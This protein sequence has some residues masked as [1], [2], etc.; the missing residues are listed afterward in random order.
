MRNLLRFAPLMLAIWSYSTPAHADT[1]YLQVTS[2][3]FNPEL[4]PVVGPGNIPCAEYTA[5]DINNDWNNDIVAGCD[6]DQVVVNWRGT[7]T[8][9][10]MTMLVVQHISNKNMVV[11]FLCIRLKGA[12]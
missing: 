4:G 6:Y 9:P 8:V 11:K 7:L 12:L 5:D 10:V 3:K 1:G 2:Y